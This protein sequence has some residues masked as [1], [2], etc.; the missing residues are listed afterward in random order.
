[1]SKGGDEVQEE[2]EIVTELMDKQKMK[3]PVTGLTI[4][5]QNLKNLLQCIKDS[6]KDNYPLSQP[7]KQGEGSSSVHEPVNNDEEQDDQNQNMEGTEFITPE[8]VEK[9]AAKLKRLEEEEKQK[10]IREAEEAV[11]AKKAKAEAERK[12]KEAEAARLAKEE[13]LR[14]EAETAELARKEAEAEE[15]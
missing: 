2:E 10:M 1:M 3:A 14:K 6:R 15:K 4:K 7:R 9:H 12:T 11:C 13:R 5:E 8:D